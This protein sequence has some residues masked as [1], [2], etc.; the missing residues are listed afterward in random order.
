MYYLA[1]GMNTNLE[2][3]A[4]RC[5]LAISLGKVV[6]NDHALRFR[7]HADA[8][9]CPGADMECVLWDITSECEK[10]LDALE[11][12]PEYYKKKMVR[13]SFGGRE[14]EA[15]I[16]YMASQEGLMTPSQDYYNNVMIGY[17]QHGIDLSKLTGAYLETLEISGNGRPFTQWT[18]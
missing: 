12:F 10:S 4:R 7:F 18:T 15:M 16:Y 14:I 1:Y 3:M 13:V 5:P 11:S 9:C 8:E 2:G 17:W 6:L